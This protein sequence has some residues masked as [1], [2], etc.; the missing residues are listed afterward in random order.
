MQLI[1][2]YAQKQLETAHQTFRSIG[3]VG[4]ARFELATP[5]V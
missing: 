2:E 5:A 1:D 3:M 4:A